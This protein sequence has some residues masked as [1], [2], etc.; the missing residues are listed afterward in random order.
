LSTNLKGDDSPAGSKSKT[1]QNEV[2]QGKNTPMEQE[3]PGTANNVVKYL[4]KRQQTPSLI[5]K[6][7]EL[8][9]VFHRSKNFSFNPSPNRDSVYP[10]ESSK[11]V[12]LAVQKAPRVLP[13]I[14]RVD[15]EGEATTRSELGYTKNSLLV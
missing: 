14:E 10:N 7:T 5:A 12:I 4:K 9:P 13:S 2:N 1:I 6:K 3:M 8:R 15:F 11:R